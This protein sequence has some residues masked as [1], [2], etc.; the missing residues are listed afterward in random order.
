MIERNLFYY[1]IF[2]VIFWIEACYGFVSEELLPFAH[3]DA[4]QSPLFF[5]ADVALVVLGFKTI[6]LLRDK[7]ILWSFVAIAVL[8]TLVINHIGMMALINGSRQFIGMLFFIPITRYLMT[9]DQ[10]AIFKKKIDK[11]LYIFLWIQA[12]CLVEQFVRYGAGDH[13]GGSMGNG[14]S[15]TVSSMICLISFYLA[16]QNWDEDNYFASMKANKKYIFLLFPVFLNETKISF[17]YIIIYF[18]LLYRYKV[19]NIGKL[20]LVSPIFIAAILGMY[21]VYA[22]VTD[23]GDKNVF[24]AEYLNAYLVGNDIDEIIT[25][26][27]MAADDE[28]EEDY[29][30]FID[31][32]RFLKIFLIPETLSKTNGGMILG[33]GLGQFKGGSTLEK[34]RFSTENKWVLNGSIFMIYIYM[35]QLGVVG[36][37]WGLSSFIAVIRNQ[38]STI[39]HA[40]QNRLYLIAMYIAALVYLPLL[41]FLQFAV[42]F[43]YICT[44]STIPV[45]DSNLKN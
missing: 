3:L 18:V 5:L 10:G 25:Y 12:F 29:L 34:T 14:A 43:Y 19:Q 6:T 9:C 16:S 42:V 36:L 7:I 39:R 8:S 24:S 27:Q 2:I 37:L 28:Y 21:N 1:R 38:G 20:I 22:Y 40:L 35:I 17:I 15:G 11:Q 31:M 41:T 33:A 4:L 45:T 26:S 30:W 32:P 23:V 44:V 13:G